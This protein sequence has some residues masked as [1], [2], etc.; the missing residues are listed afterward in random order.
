MQIIYYHVISIDRDESL[1]YTEASKNPAEDV[2]IDQDSRRAVEDSELVY[3]HFSIS[4]S[5]NIKR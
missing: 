3:L 4:F 2:A 1:N 5:L